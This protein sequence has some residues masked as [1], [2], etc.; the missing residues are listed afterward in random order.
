MLGRTEQ[1]VYQKTPWLFKPLVPA[2]PAWVSH[3]R[4]GAASHL[5]HLHCPPEWVDA[6][7]IRIDFAWPRL[8]VSLDPEPHT[9]HLDTDPYTMNLDTDPCTLNLPEP[10]TLNLGTLNR[11]W[12]DM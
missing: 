2:K 9:L 11:I 5:R 10:C 3:P 8:R 1:G 4:C 6:R 12:F 7:P